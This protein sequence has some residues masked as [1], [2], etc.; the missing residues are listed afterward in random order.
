MTT[1][2]TTETTPAEQRRT[3]R[4]AIVWLGNDRAAPWLTLAP[5]GAEFVQREDGAW[6]LA[7]PIDFEPLSD[8]PGVFSEA[9]VG[10]VGD[11]TLYV[12]NLVPPIEGVARGDIIGFNAGDL[13]V[14]P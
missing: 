3:R 8:N 1:E 14:Y 6:V 7:K 10:L 5:A 12:C 11:T 13:E 4:N 9:I 2:A